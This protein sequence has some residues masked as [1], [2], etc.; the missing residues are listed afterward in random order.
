MK[1]QIASDG[2]RKDPELKAILEKYLQDCKWAWAAKIKQLVIREGEPAQRISYSAMFLGGLEAA[3]ER[4]DIMF[5][6]E[7]ILAES[8]AARLGERAET[9][10]SV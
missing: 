6:M 1:L 2:A 5:E 8:E 3:E 9:V 4:I 10:K 7:E